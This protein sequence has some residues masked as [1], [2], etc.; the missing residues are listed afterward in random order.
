MADEATS[1]DNLYPPAAIGRIIDAAGGFPKSSPGD[2]RSDDEKR[3]ELVDALE[4]AANRLITDFVAGRVRPTASR[5]RGGPRP[6]EIQAFIG[7]IQGIW[8]DVFD[9]QF[10]TSY[11]GFK[12]EAAGPLVRFAEACFGELR[13]SLVSRPYPVVFQGKT[14]P[15]EQATLVRELG[16]T[17]DAIRARLRKDGWPGVIDRLEELLAQESVPT[18]LT[19]SNASNPVHPA[20]SERE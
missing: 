1:S 14:R 13:D 19:I 3:R 7:E 10:R 8:L 12:G 6:R 11:D 18:G 4:F 17:R 20:P 9:R 5:G 16:A 15:K 2:R